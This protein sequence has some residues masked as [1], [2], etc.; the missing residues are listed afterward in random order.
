MRA[1]IHAEAGMLDRAAWE[2]AD[3]E[4]MIKAVENLY[5]PYQCGCYDLVIMPP[6]FPFGG[7]EHARLSFI[8]PTVITGDRGQV[9]LISHELSHSWSGNFVANGTWRDLWLNEGVTRYVENRV[10]EELYGKK[11]AD[12]DFEA[13]YADALAEIGA[14]PPDAQILAIDLRG[15]HPDAALRICR[16]QKAYCFSIY[17]QTRLG[18]KLSTYF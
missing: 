3:P 9:D 10:I 5:G 8:T 11:R 7:M 6:S 15:Q 2:F 16:T 12:M 18:V 4:K 14:L 13:S 17:W 1:G